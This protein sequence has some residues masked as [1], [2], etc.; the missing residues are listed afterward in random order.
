MTQYLLT[1]RRGA[2]DT[3][4]ILS[5]SVRFIHP[6]AIKP[7]MATI[8]AVTVLAQRV[9]PDVQLRDCADFECKQR[10]LHHKGPRTP[11]TL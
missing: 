4:E 7:L 11:Q 8:A 6:S 3:E 1:N 9:D 10:E 2:E 5:A